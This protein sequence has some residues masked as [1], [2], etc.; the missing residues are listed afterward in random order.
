MVQISSPKHCFHHI[1]F[2]WSK[3]I[4]LLNV[5][6]SILGGLN[7]SWYLFLNLSLYSKFSTTFQGKKSLSIIFKGFCWFSLP[8]SDCVS[9]LGREWGGGVLGRE[10]AQIEIGTETYQVMIYQVWRCLQ[11]S[12]GGRETR[13][14]KHIWQILYVYVYT[15]THTYEINLDKKILISVLNKSTRKHCWGIWIGKSWLTWPYN[16]N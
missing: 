15:H 5:K 10:G 12:L 2:F 1:I 7:C 3:Q 4:V 8:V 14:K 11:E 9:V 6:S 13:W 16:I